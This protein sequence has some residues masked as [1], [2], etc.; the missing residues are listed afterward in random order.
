MTKFILFTLLISLHTIAGFGIEAY[1]PHSQTDR[2]STIRLF[3]RKG[4]TKLYSQKGIVS[5][6]RLIAGHKEDLNTGRAVLR[7]DGYCSSSASPVENRNI[8]HERSRQLKS[9]LIIQHGLRE[10]HFITRNHTTSP[11]K[12]KDIGVTVRLIM[13]PTPRKDEKTILA[14]PSPQ[15]SISPVSRTP[16]LLNTKSPQRPFHFA[17]KTNLLFDLATVANLSVELQITPKITTDI[18]V[19]FSPYKIKDTYQLRVLAFQPEIRYWLHDAFTGS[20]LGLHANIGW[21]NI[22][23]NDK[24][25]YQDMETVYGGGIS[26][27]YTYLFSPRWGM[28]FNIGG[29]YMHIRYGTYYNIPKGARYNTYTLN[30]WGITRLGINLQ[31]KF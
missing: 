5:L 21:F 10:E 26:Y 17:I 27:G 3:F 8:A 25:R 31:Y 15:L 20:F 7:V 13:T 16:G 2:D 22:T 28:E 14:N 11:G 29:G 23:L 4:D 6:A 30:Y 1:R 18:P 12:Q 9:Y 19:L 24:T